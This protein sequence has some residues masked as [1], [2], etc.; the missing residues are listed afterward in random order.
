[1]DRLASER[2]EGQQGRQSRQGQKRKGRRQEESSLG[3]DLEVVGGKRIRLSGKAVL[4]LREGL[5]GKASPGIW[6]ENYGRGDTPGGPPQAPSGR[7]QGGGQG[8]EFFEEAGQMS[9]L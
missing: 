1:M 5:G 3:E 6:G 9:E 4:P 8:S 7:E 2:R